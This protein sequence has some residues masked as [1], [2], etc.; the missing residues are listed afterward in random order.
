M[1]PPAQAAK[2]M[3]LYTRKNAYLSLRQLR[4]TICLIVKRQRLKRRWSGANRSISCQ[5]AAP[6][7]RSSLNCDH[8]V[9]L[10]L[11]VFLQPVDTRC[12]SI[13]RSDI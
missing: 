3:Q 5:A 10:V 7:R 11:K 9:V 13:G 6:Y 12:H 8:D 2:V 1:P 4:L